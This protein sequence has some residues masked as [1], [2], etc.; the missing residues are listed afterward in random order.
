MKKRIL[1]LSIFI[2]LVG[3]S[4]VSAQDLLSDLLNTFDESMVIL[5]A[6][7]IISFSIV[8]F[9]LNKSLFKENVVIAGVISAIVAFL[10]TYGINKTGFD[11]NGFF[12]DIGVP[13]NIL[14]TLIPIVILAG[15][16]FAIIKL[17]TNSLFVFGGLLIVLSFFVYA[18][19]LLIIVGIILLV[20]GLALWKSRKGKGFKDAGAG[21]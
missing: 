13:E 8:F 9:A 20:I 7:F 18:K 1:A 19:A 14:M 17:G 11:F 6:V 15:I 3:I 10:I 16:V 21:I 12:V 4:F 5:S 2:F